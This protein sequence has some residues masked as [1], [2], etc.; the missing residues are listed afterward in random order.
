MTQRVFDLDVLGCSRCG[1]RLRLIA[2]IQDPDAIRSILDCRGLSSHPAPS[3]G[4]TR[5]ECFSNCS[6]G[7]TPAAPA[8]VCALRTLILPGGPL[9]LERFALAGFR[10]PR[11]S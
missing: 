2:A 9:H 4:P 6:P 11:P 7:A 3:L 8:E 10:H 5:S 1:G